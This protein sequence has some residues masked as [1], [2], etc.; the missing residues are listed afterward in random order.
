MATG[1]EAQIC[2]ALLS[3]LAALTLSPVLPVAYPDV[4][5]TPPKDGSNKPLPYL[6]AAMMQVPTRGL[7]ITGGTNAFS[8][9]MQVTV[10]Y[11][12][13]SGAIK[14]QQ[15]AA[16]I[17]AWFKKDSTFTDGTT[18][19]RIIQPPYVSPSY[20]DA[21]YTRTPITVPYVSYLPQPA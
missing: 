12:Q 18:K 17:I 1:S 9:M 5:F 7:A 16:S 8:G 15:I 6:E 11:P 19:V 2:Q 13:N 14:S 20:A 4:A 10:C 21:T 3:R